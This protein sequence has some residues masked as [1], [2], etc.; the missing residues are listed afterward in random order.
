M[1]TETI[2]NVV[3]KFRLDCTGVHGEVRASKRWESE[4]EDETHRGL[5]IS[6]N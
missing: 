2:L 4:K 6:V 5:P 3:L 1:R